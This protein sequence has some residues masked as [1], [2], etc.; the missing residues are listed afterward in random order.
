LEQSAVC[1][2][3]LAEIADETS[4]P[5][6]VVVKFVAR[7][8]KEVHKFLADHGYAP[9]LR[10]HGSL[11]G[12]QLSGILPGPAQQAPPGLCL[13]S[14][15]I[16]MVIMDYILPSCGGAPPDVLAQMEKILHLLHSEGY[17]FGDLR[18]P[19]IL[20]D[21]QGRVK[22]IDF[23]W[24]ERYNMNICDENLPESLQ[25]EIDKNKECIQVGNGPYVYY[26]LSMST[27]DGMW[28]P[29]MQPLTLIRPQHD[30]MMLDKLLG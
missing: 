18:Q 26:L 25:K 9:T 24:C 21:E 17:V 13:W 2:T 28:A 6:K 23:N 11:P 14:D 8:G 30:W 7:Y 12:T 22:L 5:V 4:G 27:V 3:Y 1:V 20:F 15:L 16:H 29:G 10:Y 19:N